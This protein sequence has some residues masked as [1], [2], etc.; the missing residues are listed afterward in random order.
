VTSTAS[1]PKESPVDPNQR[2]SE[3]EFT[4]LF[5]NHVHA[6]CR[7]LRMVGVPPAHIEDAA[8]EVF[9]VI[10]DKLPT[11]DRSGSLHGYISGVAYRVGHNF[12]RK[13]RKLNIVSLQDEPTDK[14]PGVNTENSTLDAGRLVERF[15][16]QLDDPMR[17]VFVLVMLEERPSSEV[18][19]LLGISVNTVYSR[20]RLLREGFRKLLDTPRGGSP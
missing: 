4:Q 5:S 6:V 16:N 18:A 15:A 19:D 1:F 14:V 7:I 11:L 13:Y 10:H 20:V 8:Q 17:D 12:R 2:G 9:L 3:T